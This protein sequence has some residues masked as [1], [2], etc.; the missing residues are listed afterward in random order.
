MTI[1]CEKGVDTSPHDCVEYEVAADE[2]VSM[3]VV[4]AVARASGRDPTG[5]GG[6]PNSLDPLAE[7][8]SPEALDRIFES[9]DS[10]PDATT[11]VEFD[12]C[13]YRVV[14]EAA[15]SVTVTVA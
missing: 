5:V 15:G 8:I 9:T 10:S 12:Y 4:H 1:D 6:T 3:A 2:P 11:A 14:V 13:D 7:T